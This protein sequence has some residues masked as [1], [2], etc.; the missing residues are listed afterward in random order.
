MS[1]D[2]QTLI[3]KINKKRLSDV[4]L[5]LIENTVKKEKIKNKLPTI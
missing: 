1:E 5:C 4:L 3:I 2:M